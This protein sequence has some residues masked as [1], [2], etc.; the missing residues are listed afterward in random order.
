MY[1]DI[2]YKHCIILVKPNKLYFLGLEDRIYWWT[3]ITS[4]KEITNWFFF[5]CL[6]HVVH[7]NLWKLNRVLK[8]S[9]F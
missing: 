8:V 9:S 5:C 1:N 4:S 6:K 3:I 2:E 7:K